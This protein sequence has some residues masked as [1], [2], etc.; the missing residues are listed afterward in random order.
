[1]YEFF[2]DFLY[3]KYWLCILKHFLLSMYKTKQTFYHMFNIVI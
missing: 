2:L 1:M 3:L